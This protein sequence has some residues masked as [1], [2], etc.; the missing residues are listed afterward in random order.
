M[1]QEGAGRIRHRPEF[2]A[3]MHPRGEGFQTHLGVVDAEDGLASCFS[4]SHNLLYRYIDRNL[5]QAG[6]CAA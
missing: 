6:A 4:E 3:T 1:Q 5:Q 2:K